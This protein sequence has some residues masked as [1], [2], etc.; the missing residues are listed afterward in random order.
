MG[1]EWGL[2]DQDSFP[3]RASWETLS[4]GSLGGTKKGKIP[5]P[6]IRGED[7]E[8]KKNKIMYDRGKRSFCKEG[9]KPLK[10]TPSGHVPRLG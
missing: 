8:K 5:A 3:H 7:G 10:G 9:R 4:D 1:W 6:R 2:G